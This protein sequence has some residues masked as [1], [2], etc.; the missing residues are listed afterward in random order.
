MLPTSVLNSSEP[1]AL[2][3][4]KLAKEMKFDVTCNNYC[5]YKFCPYAADNKAQPCGQGQKQR[6]AGR[7]KAQCFCIHPKCLKG[8]HPSCWSKAH[9]FL[10]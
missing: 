1:H 9:G 7:S 5:S 4:A 6:Q 10:Q 3:E 8:Y 2:V